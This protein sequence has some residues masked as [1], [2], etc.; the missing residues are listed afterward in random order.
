[1]LTPVLYLFWRF[2]MYRKSVPILA[3]L[4]ISGGMQQ[5]HAADQ[6]DEFQQAAAESLVLFN[7]QAAQELQDELDAQIAVERYEQIQQDEVFAH[8]VSEQQVQEQPQQH[9][10]G[11][12][13]EQ[14]AQEEEHNAELVE[15]IQFSHILNDEFL[16][17]EL[18]S[19]FNG[20]DPQIAPEQ[21]QVQAQDQTCAICL[22]EEF[23]G[24][25]RTL[26]CSH[27]FHEGCINQWF[28][29]Q[30]QPGGLFQDAGSFPKTCPL[31]NAPVN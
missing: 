10:A 19:Q 29:K 23:A 15:A 9:D 14:P 16:A 12:H 4:I 2:I 11:P 3:A 8:I 24:N 28:N 1:M 27:V 26:P 30:Q 18:F 22:G 5:L 6:P 7:Q 20:E 13:E 25:A 21:P 17:R 31:C